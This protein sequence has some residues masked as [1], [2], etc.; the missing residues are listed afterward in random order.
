MS[1][2]ALVLAGGAGTRFWPASRARRP[3]QLLPLATE[4]PLIVDTISRV[5]HIVG[6]WEKVFIASGTAVAEPTRE[7]L[8]ELPERNLLVEPAPR[9]TAPC[10]AWAA[11]TIARIDPNAIVMVLPSDHHIEKQ[12]AFQ[13]ALEAAIASARSGVITTI[14]L[15]PTRP[16]TGYGYI[17]VA[18]GEGPVRRVARFTEKPNREKAEEFVRGGRHLW[19][20][21][22]FI[23][24]AG[25]MLRAIDR[26]L[27]ELAEGLRVL[28][29]AAEAG[30]EHEALA[31]VF[32][33]LPSV[34]I[35]FGV[36]EKLDE[37]AVVPAD[38]GWS[39]IG[40]W[41]AAAELS[42]KGDLGNAGPDG[43]VFVEAEGNHV[44]DLR[45]PH[46]D[47]K[48]VIAL[49]GVKDLVVVETDDALLIVPRERS[50][51]VKHVVDAL[52]SRGDTH[53]T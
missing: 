47:K 20:A 33:S 9:N 11:A 51:D 12:D 3:K 45:S 40:S 19:N 15:T 10:I 44:V 38:L 6:G 52:K 16:D 50:Q 36:M 53:Y 1:I 4:A 7:M 18:E 8:P 24:R 26:H 5:L 48:R 29:A 27:P 21:G 35:D 37:L 22:M 13:A 49:V 23:F 34:S 31:K 32:P 2:Y 14:G 46:G 43:T 25:D 17:E 30:A 39:D 41:E 42:P 28:D